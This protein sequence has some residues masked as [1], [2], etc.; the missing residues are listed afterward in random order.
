MQEEK[1]PSD[2]LL[3]V[4]DELLIYTQHSYRYTSALEEVS[5]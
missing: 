3:H 5:A 2:H 4:L 1:Y